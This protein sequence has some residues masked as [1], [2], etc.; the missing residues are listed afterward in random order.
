[1]L[2]DALKD[3]EWL[4]E[5][6]E[7]SFSDIG[8]KIRAHEKTDFWQ[9]FRH[10]LHQDNGHFFYREMDGDFSMTV[11]WSFIDMSGFC[12]CG[13]MGR[14]DEANWFKMSL[15]SETADPRILGVSVTNFGLSDW[16]TQAVKA[17]NGE[18][19]Y[20]IKAEKGTITLSYS[21]NGKDFH[22]VRMFQ[23]LK[24]FEKFMAGAYICC[25]RE[26]KFSALLASVELDIPTKIY[27]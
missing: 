8:V 6:S 4:N 23:P 9:D 12:Q 11:K 20:R 7:V 24:D 1:M 18:I 26:R 10:S 5:P 25:P 13:L 2:L 15:I 17:E 22:Q 16:A 14:I 19:W 3:F 21:L 27:P